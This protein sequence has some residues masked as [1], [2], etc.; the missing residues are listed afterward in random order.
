[1]HKN[2]KKLQMSKLDR[3]IQIVRENMVAN[4]PGQGGAFSGSSPNEGPTAGFDPKTEL[5]MFRRTIGG[6]VDKRTKQ[7]HQKY[8]KWLKSMGLL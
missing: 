6:L 1:V 2:W 3:V 5:G 7:Y 4:S 8:E